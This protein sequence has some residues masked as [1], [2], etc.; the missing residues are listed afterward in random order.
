MLQTARLLH[1]IYYT[2]PATIASD[3]ATSLSYNAFSPHFP[4]EWN[5]SPYKHR[6]PTYAQYR[7]LQMLNIYDERTQV[8][9]SRV[10]IL[11]CAR[12]RGY[13]WALDAILA[14]GLHESRRFAELAGEVFVEV[15]WVFERS[16]SE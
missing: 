6:R 8:S 11:E 13:K 4:Q 12:R 10:Q 5:M 7:F 14:L 9:S 2:S 15:R 3:L 1:G 16:W